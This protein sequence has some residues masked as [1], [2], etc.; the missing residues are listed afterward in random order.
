MTKH[1]KYSREITINLQ[2]VLRKKCVRH[3]GGNCLRCQR[4]WEKN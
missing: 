3:E 2:G 4:Q 1:Q